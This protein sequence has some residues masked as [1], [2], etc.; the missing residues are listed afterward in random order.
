MPPDEALAATAGIAIG[1]AGYR[2]CLW[3][4]FMETL[5]VNSPLETGHKKQQ[6]KAEQIKVGERIRRGQ[7]WGA[8]PHCSSKIGVR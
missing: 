3:R 2:T 1:R 4:T 6:A 8:W 5:P 7:G